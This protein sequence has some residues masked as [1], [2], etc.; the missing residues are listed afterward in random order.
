MSYLPRAFQPMLDATINS[1]LNRYTHA[2]DCARLA[3][4]KMTDI[5]RAVNNQPLLLHSS[6]SATLVSSSLYLHNTFSRPYCL[7][8]TPIRR[9]IRIRTQIHKYLIMLTHQPRTQIW[10]RHIGRAPLKRITR[11]SK[12]PIRVLRARKGHSQRS[13]VVA[14][15]SGDDCVQELLG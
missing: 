13:T 14:C 1:S 12:R 9:L 3:A 15:C 11:P 10:P 7:I 8:C 5:T 6:V 2:I 4:V